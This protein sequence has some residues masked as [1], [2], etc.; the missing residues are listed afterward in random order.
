MKSFGDQFLNQYD[1]VSPL[2]KNV[3]DGKVDSATVEEELKILEKYLIIKGVRKEIMDR[4]L[5]VSKCTEL[6]KIILARL[7]EL[8]PIFPKLADG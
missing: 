3:E 1:E 5:S 8:L 7:G 6:C 2:L 4:E